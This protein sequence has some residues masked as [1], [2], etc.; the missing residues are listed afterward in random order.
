MQIGKFQSRIYESM[1]GVPAGSILGPVLFLIHIDDVE[2]VVRFALL[3]MFA[4]DVKMI[5]KVNSM[6]D[7]KLPQMDI[8]SVMKWSEE[9][10]L[11]LNPG[12]CCV[13][14]IRRTRKYYEG[15]YT[16]GN[17]VIE[18]KNENRDLGLL[19]DEK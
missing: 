4:D 12:K 14:T 15:G 11:P 18:R 19:V 17:H 10:S 2:K 6:D 16:M 13:L 1:S 3:S 9:N 5:M 7:T 8:D